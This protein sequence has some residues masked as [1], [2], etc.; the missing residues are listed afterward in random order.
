MTGTTELG[1]IADLQCG[2]WSTTILTSKGSLHTAGMLNGMQ[3]FGFRSEFS[4]RRPQ[5][6]R[7]PAGA[8]YGATLGAYEEPTVAIRQFSAGR[9]HI[10]GLSDSG[11]IWSWYNVD[12]P[13]MHVKFLHVG[14]TEASSR[15]SSPAS[16][17]LYG[18][19]KQVL[20]GWSCSSAYIYGVGIVVWDP[21]RRERGEDPDT[22]TAMV[23]E[24][25]EVPRTGYLRPKGH[26]R[27]SEEERILGEE[28]GMVLNYILLENYVVFVTDIGKVFCGKFG[29]KNQ[30]REVLELPALRSESKSPLDVQ[31][32][33]RRFA[34]FKDGEVITPTQD[35][36][37]TCW[38]GRF[39]L[40]LS[41][42]TQGLQRIPA[43]QQ[44]NVISVAFG[45]YHFHALHSTG[46][47]TSYG[48]ELRCCG[49][50]GLGRGWE[51]QRQLRGIYGALNIDRHLLPHAYT[52]GRQ[53]WFEPEKQKWLDFLER[54]GKDREEATDRMQMVNTDRS[55]LAEVSEWIEQE[56]KAWEKDLGIEDDDGLGLY[57]AL[58]ISAAGWHSGALVLHNEELSERLRQKC[59]IQEAE[60][61][62][63]KGKE[64]AGASGSWNMAALLS[65]C[66][67]MGRKFLGLHGAD[68]ENNTGSVETRY[69]WSDTSFPRL[70]LSDGR[71]MPGTVEFNEWR[72]GV[73]QFQLDIDGLTLSFPG[74]DV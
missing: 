28:V 61:S 66:A 48:T 71:E 21:V 73:P 5:A 42:I 47:I 24:N 9:T 62:S 72:E 16:K 38:N 14:I 64:K 7:F 59:I 8:L 12:K 45:D 51:P 13:A 2:G 34:I 11:R 19:V 1:I 33:F 39:D 29:D 74:Q 41:T 6:L 44:N 67:R 17:P 26:S 49:A 37:E 25:A 43:L 60:T 4:D 46:R 31:G 32:S 63:Q 54:G 23:M 69:I 22:D 40:D 65:W 57:F 30:I 15:Q 18:R 35:Y 3:D 56:S 68:R 55:V 36:L 70:K 27:E 20:A 50:L 58:S 53:V 52:S 10:L